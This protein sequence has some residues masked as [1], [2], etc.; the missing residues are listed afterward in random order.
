[1]IEVSYTTSFHQSHAKRAEL[2]F[3]WLVQENTGYLV[4]PYF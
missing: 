2:Y 3:G 4:T 1:V